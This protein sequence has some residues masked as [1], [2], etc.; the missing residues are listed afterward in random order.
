MRRLGFQ[1]GTEAVDAIMRWYDHDSSGR[2]E[3]YEF[4]IMARD[5]SVFT[6]FDSDHA[7]VLDAA[8]LRPALAKLGLAASEPEVRRII[9]ASR[10]RSPMFASVNVASTPMHCARPPPGSPRHD[11]L[12]CIAWRGVGAHPH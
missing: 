1:A 9:D 5:V 11:A 4:A 6:A 8:K 2:I 10:W 7:G 3:L 12:G